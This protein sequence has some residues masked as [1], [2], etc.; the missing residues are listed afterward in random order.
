MAT[1][2]SNVSVISPLPNRNQVDGL[3][4]VTRESDAK[5]IM[6][7]HYRQLRARRQAELIWEKLMLHV[8]GSGELQ[9]ADIFR[10]ERVVVPPSVS[11]YRQ[12]ENLLRVIVSNAVA[13]H[14]T[15]P[16]RYAVDAAPDR[17]SR[18]S[19]LVDTI[20]ANHLAYDQDLNSLFA[21]ALTIAMSTGFCPV[22]AYWRDDV[23]VDHYEGVG[24]RGPAPGML[25]CWVGS[26]FDTVFNPG[27]TRGNVRWCSYSRLVN[28]DMVRAAYPNARGLEGT[29]RAASASTFQRIA[30]QWMNN[31][32]GVHGDPTIHGR[33]GE[34]LLTLICRETAPVGGDGG[35]MQLIAVAGNGD[36]RNGGSGGHAVML[37]DQPLPGGDW[38]WSL[39]YSDWR[40]N[41]IHGKPWI[42]DLDESQMQLNIGISKEWEMINRISHAPILSPGG[43]ISD[44]MT[45]LGDGIPIIEF[46]PGAANWMPRPLDFHQSIFPALERY[47]ESRRAYIY[48]IGGYQAASRGEAPGSR[49]A[50][51]AIVALQQA[52]TSVHGPVNARYR[53][54]GC[55]FMRRC[56]KQMKEYGDIPMMVSVLGDEYAH[57]ADSWVSSGDLS[58]RVPRYRMVQAFGANPEMRA[59]ELTQMVQM[60]GADGNPILKT[61]EYRRLYPDPVIFASDTDPA[62]VQRR[63][64]RTVAAKIHEMAIAFRQQTGVQGN[65]IADPIVLQAGMALFQYAQKLFPPM[66]D[67]DFTAHL[68]ALSE[69]TQDETADPIARV[70]AQQFQNVY[71]QWQAQMSAGQG[72]PAQLQPAPPEDGP[73]GASGQPPPVNRREIA[74]DMAN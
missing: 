31:G 16:I 35:R 66:R 33:D 67:D 73:R 19:A 23:E 25:D 15:A 6:E 64:A 59:Q 56:W 44:D 4:L 34:E 21:S 47:I 51:R 10:G 30:R 17:K 60:R 68:A 48:R 20:W 58:N 71:F 8:D 2:E 57:L 7:D 50:Y 62:V 3:G 11:E 46:E 28:A 22:H 43:A 1:I 40:G 53:Q 61:D 49:M 63:R 13:Q 54:S 5:R 55:D 39:F 52:D 41:D 27:A 37:A 26:P 38:S 70:V 36:H 45:Y 14:T 24:G 12:Q 65:S 69:I 74:A 42:E 72:A 29:T 9:W 32:L 18:D